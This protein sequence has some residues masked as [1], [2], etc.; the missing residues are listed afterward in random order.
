MT[1]HADID[2]SGF[3]KGFY[4]SDIHDAKTIPKTAVEITKDQ[5]QDWLV[6][7]NTRR[8]EK[9]ALVA[10]PPAPSSSH[11]LVDGK[12]VPDINRLK[13]A[14]VAKLSI[15]CGVACEVGY[16]SNATDSNHL[17][18]T[19]RTDGQLNLLGHHLD[20]MTNSADLDWTQKITCVPE[21][22]TTSTRVAHT[23]AQTLAVTV[24]VKQMIEGNRTIYN[25]KKHYVLNL[26]PASPTIE[27]DIAAVTWESVEP[28]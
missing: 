14:K 19:D 16:T 27:E 7:Q 20:A 24:P 5:Y 9:D 10:S 28:Q 18:A 8:W 13:A 17:Y 22:E 3:V 15:A 26:D 11:E 4:D 12:W 6:N 23:A 21:G 1:K 25:D 2:N